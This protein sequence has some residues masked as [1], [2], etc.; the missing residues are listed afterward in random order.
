MSYNNFVIMILFYFHSSFFAISEQTYTKYVG[1]T[2]HDKVSKI[3]LL[4]TVVICNNLF[5]KHGNPDYENG[6]VNRQA[7]A[8][9]PLITPPLA[10]I[11]LALV[12]HGLTT[13][14]I[15]IYNFIVSVCTQKSVCP[16][17][18]QT[19]DVLWQT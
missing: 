5:Q 14:Y 6:L 2:L 10:M 19:L 4:Q 15:Y 17:V 18:T 7:T 3:I 9:R 8:Q 1:W 11:T 13:I 16:H 12:K